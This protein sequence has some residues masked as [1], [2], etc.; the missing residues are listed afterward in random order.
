MHLDVKVK[1]RFFAVP[2]RQEWGRIGWQLGPKSSLF[3]SPERGEMELLLFRHLFVT[4]N[5]YERISIL[6]A[7]ASTSS[8]W[9]L[10]NGQYFGQLREASRFMLLISPALEEMR[11]SMC[12]R[13]GDLL[14]ASQ[15][16]SPLSLCP[17]RGASCIGATGSLGGTC[18]RQKF[19]GLMAL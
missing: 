15:D 6:P 5:I 19:G 16:Q 13:I 10:G 12:G 4:C 8:W 1:M 14:P 18:G 2:V 11:T 9:Q 17:Q 3:M 7:V